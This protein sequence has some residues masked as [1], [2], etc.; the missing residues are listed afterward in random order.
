MRLTAYSR[1]AWLCAGLA[2][3]EALM[4][5]P[6]LEVSWPPLHHTQP[7]A[8]AHRW[9]PVHVMMSSVRPTARRFMSS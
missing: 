4:K 7:L 6:Q 9:S 5:S 8:Q 1:W 3:C 2:S